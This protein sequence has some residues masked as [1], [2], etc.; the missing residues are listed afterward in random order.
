MAASVRD[1]NRCTVVVSDSPRRRSVGHA[2]CSPLA[3]SRRGSGELRS[4]TP[5][6]TRA[7]PVG[8]PGDARRLGEPAFQPYASDTGAIFRRVFARSQSA[9]GSCPLPMHRAALRVMLRGQGPA[10]LGHLLFSGILP[11]FYEESPCRGP[12]QR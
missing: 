4:V 10:C 1:V 9:T 5:A 7:C 11:R 8:G 2:S 12:T 6:T 3:I